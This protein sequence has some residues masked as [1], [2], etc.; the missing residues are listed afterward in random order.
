MEKMIRFIDINVP[1]KQNSAKRAAGQMLNR[2]MTIV[3]ADHLTPVA[4]R[5]KPQIN[6][7]AKAWAQFECLP[8]MDHN[9]LSGFFRRACV[10]KDIGVIFIG[11]IHA[12]SQTTDN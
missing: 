4:R 11:L 7:L 10:G 2:W 8:E 9:T 3:G 6:K 5:I 1:I 12:P